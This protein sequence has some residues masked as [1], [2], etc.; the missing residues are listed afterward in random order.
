MLKKNVVVMYYVIIFL[1][2]FSF[3]ILG[4]SKKFYNIMVLFLCYYKY[5]ENLGDKFKNDRID[6]KIL[7]KKRQIANFLFLIILIVIILTEFL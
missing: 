4:N 3:F 7:D 2:L 1:I 6:D 5:Q